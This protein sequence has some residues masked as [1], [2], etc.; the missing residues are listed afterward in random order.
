MFTRL[1]SPAF[2]PVFLPKIFALATSSQVA[3]NSVADAYLNRSVVQGAKISARLPDDRATSS[4]PFLFL[5]FFFFSSLSPF[6][7][8]SLSFFDLLSHHYP[9][10]DAS[11]SII[12]PLE[13]RNGPVRVPAIKACI[14]YSSHRCSINFLIVTFSIEIVPRS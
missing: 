2:L 5:Y 7:S 12:F 11:G 13:I 3:W 6:L 9:P 10:H 4:F 1:L 14:N 8:L